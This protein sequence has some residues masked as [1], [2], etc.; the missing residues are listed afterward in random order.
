MSVYLSS[1][2][3]VMKWKQW[4]SQPA[5]KEKQ[6]TLLLMS[7]NTYPQSHQLFEPLWT[8]PG[9]KWVELV[10]WTGACDNW[11]PPQKPNNSGKDWF[12]EPSAM[13]LACISKPQSHT[14]FKATITHSFYIENIMNSDLKSRNS[15][16]DVIRH[17][18]NDCLKPHNSFP[19]SFF[20]R[21]KKYVSSS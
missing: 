14:H 17:I 3:T 7:D 10:R 20:E 21:E 19:F 5:K 18:V 13:V 9:P 11:S 4:S 12:V 1:H 15:L 2:R 16:S 6:Y 8:D